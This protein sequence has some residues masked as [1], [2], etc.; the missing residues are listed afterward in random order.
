MQDCFRQ[1]PDTYGDE[2][3]DPGPPDD[4]ESAIAGAVE[5]VSVD[6]PLASIP[7]AAPSSPS[8]IVPT[9]SS[10]DA[11][12]TESQTPPPATL[13]A[14]TPSDAD[15]HPAHTTND[16][17][18]STTARAKSAAEQ[19]RDQHGDTGEGGDEL[20]TKEWHDTTQLKEK[21]QDP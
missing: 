7:D 3:A 5:G 13:S 9:T 8:S 18:A 14:P 16:D 4:E 10:T 11:F 17:D 2:L 12:A 19:V 15:I 20:V 6:T 21:K 1:H